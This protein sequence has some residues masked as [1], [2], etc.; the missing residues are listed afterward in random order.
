MDKVEPNV[1]IDWRIY[2]MTRDI[3][4]ARHE[5]EDRKYTVV[6]LT[7]PNRDSCR[8]LEMGRPDGHQIS[9]LMFVITNC[10]MG[11]DEQVSLAARILERLLNDALIPGGNKMLALVE[12]AVS[13]QANPHHHQSCVR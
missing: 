4:F 6:T 3:S 12:Q 2:P 5:Q 13:E 9:S 11:P 10:S 8:L 7:W 1:E